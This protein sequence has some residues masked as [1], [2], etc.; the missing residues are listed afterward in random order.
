M[1]Y[2]EQLDPVHSKAG[3]DS[4]PITKSFE[5]FS[6]IPNDTKYWLRTI[7]THWLPYVLMSK[8]I[9]FSSSAKHHNINPQLYFQTAFL[10]NYEIKR[11]YTLINCATVKEIASKIINPF[12]MIGDK[13][14]VTVLISKVNLSCFLT[15]P[16]IMMIRI[17]NVKIIYNL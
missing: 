7:D 9:I 16:Y 6:P 11:L 15:N 1:F 13:L 2:R 12:N 17:N 4:S 14:S 8:S 10:S 5:L 3:H